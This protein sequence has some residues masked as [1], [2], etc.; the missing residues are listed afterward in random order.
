VEPG[1]TAYVVSGLDY[2]DA[3]TAATLAAPEQGSVLLTR[4]GKL[5]AV[6]AAQLVAQAPARIVVV[7]G[8][9]AVSDDVL[10]ALADY[11]PTVVRVSGG[12]RYAT[13]AAVADTFDT[14][15]DVLYVA[16]G[17][18]YPDALSVAALAGQQ[19]AAVL[20]TQA[21]HLPAV[22]AEAAGRLDP[23]RIVVVGGAGA[24]SETVLEELDSY[25]R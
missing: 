12:D 7:G 22:S 11:A 21:G 17:E 10:G 23:D 1:A 5:P 13:A 20:L 14:G 8:A 15:V 19:G 9:G 4:P 3:L 25:L 2:P 18:N 6:T 16:T 24:V